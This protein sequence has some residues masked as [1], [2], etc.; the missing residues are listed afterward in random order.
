MKRNAP[1][2]GREPRLPG[3]LA[4][5][6]R[7]LAVGTLLAG[8]AVAPAAEKSADEIEQCVRKNLPSR[9]SVQ[10]VSFRVNDVGGATTD[11][12]VKIFWQQSPED[13]L[14]KVLLRFDAPLDMRG[15]AL[16][17]I[18]KPGRNDMFMYLPELRRVRRVTG[19]TLSGGMFGTDFTYSQ[20]ERLQGVARDL[21]VERLADA[22]VGDRPVWVLAHTPADDPE[23]E[24]VKSYVT[25]DDCVPLRTEFFE[26]ERRLRKVL[27]ADPAHVKP[28]GGHHIPHRLVMSDVVRGTST[29]FQVKAIDVNAEIHRKMF[30][31]AQLAQGK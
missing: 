24:Y 4:G 25:P 26:R 16:L 17:L 9:S 5:T 12:E 30:T 14:S 31:Q 27:E 20:F 22:K 3:R 21:T 6:L 2:A 7:L 23:F 11:S 10:E 1:L 29:E 19:P 18:E 13:Q 8:A 28:V 15:S